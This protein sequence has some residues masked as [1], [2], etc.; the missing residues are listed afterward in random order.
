MTAGGCVCHRA[1]PGC[2]LI[3]GLNLRRPQMTLLWESVCRG[4]ERRLEGG[5]SDLRIQ[6]GNSK[7]IYASQADIHHM[8]SLILLMQKLDFGHTHT[9][10]HTHTQNVSHPLLCAG[11]DG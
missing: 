11:C 3:P 4:W 1:E 5:G 2:R 7:Y 10:T 8:T 9:H 6:A